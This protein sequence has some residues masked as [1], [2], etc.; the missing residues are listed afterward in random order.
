MR[1]LS[2]MGSRSNSPLTEQPPLTMSLGSPSKAGQ[3]VAIMAATRWP[4]AECPEMKRRPASPP[5]EAALRYTQARAARHWRTSSSMS[6]LGMRASFTT[7]AATP[8][9]AKARATKLK[10]S[11][12]KARQ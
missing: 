9:G 7:T 3:S 5:K 4:P 2:R 1:K 10:S 11:L 12:W 6:T 8:L